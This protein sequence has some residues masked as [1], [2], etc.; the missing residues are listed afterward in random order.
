MSR[1]F[2]FACLL[3]LPAAASAQQGVEER[4]AA[5][6][7]K[8]ESLESEVESLKAALTAAESSPPEA[9][10]APP[11][12]APQPAPVTQ[13]AGGLPVYGG[14]AAMSKALN[15]DISVIGNIQGSTGHDPVRTSDAIDVEE[16]EVAF[17]SIIDPYMR[18]DVYFSF[19]D[20]GFE[21]EEGYAT[22]TSLP[23][24][25]VAKAGK[26]RAPFGKVNAMHDHTLPWVDRPLM[27]ENILGGDEGL[28]DVGVSASYILPLPFFLEATGQVYRGESEGLF[29]PERKSDVAYLARLR[30]YTDISESTNL[31]LGFTWSRGHNEFG[32]AFA[33]NLWG[34]DVTLR[35]KPLRRAIYNSFDWRTEFVV[36]DRQQPTG[37]TRAFGM[38]TSADYRLNRRWTVG[39][40]YD[41]SDR[42]LEPGLTDKG[43]SAVLTYW[44][45]EFSQIRTQ[46]RYTDYP[47]GLRG[48]ELRMQ[49]LFSMGAH[50]AHPF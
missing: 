31:D 14:A 18:G 8:I 33:T 11:A 40:R 50:G 24:G 32:S 3:F 6:E 38:F 42:A 44:P 30:S 9:A 17:S 4:L 48:N 20:H 19:G 35:W 39:G 28:N 25:L 7:K 37:T 36:S 45:S 27:S 23:W 1:T 29:Q 16:F 5:M 46:Y 47:G 12:P 34:G 41:Y 2:L 13:A 21:L 26:M 10:A 22:F 49:L 43:F 15:P